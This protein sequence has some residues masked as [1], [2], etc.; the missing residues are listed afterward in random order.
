VEREKATEFSFLLLIPIVL[1]AGTIKVGQ[2]AAAG[3]TRGQLAY[4]LAGAV[5]A[6]LSGYLA[7]KVLLWMV[8]RNQLHYFSY[9]CWLLGITVLWFMR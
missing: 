1:G 2:I 5:T 3:I 8:R 7:I 4:L 6:A 9:Y